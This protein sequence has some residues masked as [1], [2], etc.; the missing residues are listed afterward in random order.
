MRLGLAQI[1]L[2]YA[3]PLLARETDRYIH[4]PQ[5]GITIIG[6]VRPSV[7]PSVRPSVYLS[8]RPSVYL[9]VCVSVCLSVSLSVCLSVRLSVSLSV[10]LSVRLSV[11]LSVRPSVSVCLC[12]SIISTTKYYNV[13]CHISF[14]ATTRTAVWNRNGHV[15]IITTLI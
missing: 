9:S 7:W 15:V 10:C 11:C 8:V 13:S 1:E 14:Q 2:N 6:S 12:A 4:I 5:S 3:L